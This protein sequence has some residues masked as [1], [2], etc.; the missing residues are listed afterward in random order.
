MSVYNSPNLQVHVSSYCCV[1]HRPS[2]LSHTPSHNLYDPNIES[3][4]NMHTFISHAIFFIT[5]TFVS[6][7]HTLPSLRTPPPHLHFTTTTLLQRLYHVSGA[8]NIFVTGLEFSLK[9]PLAIAGH[10]DFTLFSVSA[11]NY[12]KVHQ[13]EPE[14]SCLFVVLVNALL[15]GAFGLLLLGLFLSMAFSHYTKIHHIILH[16]STQRHHVIL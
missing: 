10:M 9:S 7:T 13:Q 8:H 14:G 12:I 5:T 11:D 4:C 6:N 1:H 16:Q 3:S 2:P 15:H